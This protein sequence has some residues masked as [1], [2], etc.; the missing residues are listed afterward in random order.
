MIGE[1]KLTPPSRI[2]ARSNCLRDNGVETELIMAVVLLYVESCVRA[3]LTW[4]PSSRCHRRRHI[5]GR[6]GFSGLCRRYNPLRTLTGER[7]G[8]AAF[9]A[10]GWFRGSP[11]LRPIT[12][13][14]ESEG[15]GPP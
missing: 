2:D 12:L 15:L 9:G 3:S 6:L 8:V 10:P 14:A 11:G 1:P 13:P 4:S 5:F 7:Y